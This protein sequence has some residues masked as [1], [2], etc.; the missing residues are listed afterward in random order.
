MQRDEIV[1][2]ERRPG[3]CPDLWGF[4]EP[5]VTGAAVLNVG[6][7]G[8]V[9]RYLEGHRSEWLHAWLSER[10]ADLVGLDI[11]EESIEFAR[12]R[13]ETSLVCGDCE[14]VDLGR[15]FDVIVFSEVIEHV[16][17][18]VRAL[19]NLLRHLSPEGCILL[20][21]PN[22]TYYAGLVRA[23]VNAPM[24]IYYDHVTAFF[25]ENVVV[26]CNRLGACVTDVRF[27]NTRD[28]RT[29]GMRLKSSVAGFVGRLIPRLGSNFVCVIEARR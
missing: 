19:D 18:P 3:R 1:V 25:P 8:N 16:A 20:T 9:E 27:Y 26:I 21:T 11:D 29:L 6:A 24:G 17:S 13:G 15:Q 28:R 10:A 22:P 14:T 4:L 2:L 23:F 7:A 5:F 12:T